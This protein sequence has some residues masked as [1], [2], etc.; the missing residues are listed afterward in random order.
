MDPIIN[1]MILSTLGNEVLPV[2]H[3]LY[4]GDKLHMMVMKCNL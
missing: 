2:R 3:K 1:I 4:R